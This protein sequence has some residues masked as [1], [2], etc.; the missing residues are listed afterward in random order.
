MFALATVE[1]HS[2]MSSPTLRPLDH[3]RPGNN[4]FRL[5]NFRGIAAVAL[6]TV[7]PIVKCYKEDTAMGQ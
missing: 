6:Y 3:E 1:P 5:Q 2:S 7:L 4:T